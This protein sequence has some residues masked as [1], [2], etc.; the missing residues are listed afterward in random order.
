MNLAFECFSSDVSQSN[1]S[2]FNSFSPLMNLAF[3]SYIADVKQLYIV[4]YF[5]GAELYLKI[6]YNTLIFTFFGKA[7]LFDGSSLTE[8]GSPFKV[9]FPMVAV[10]GSNIVA[11]GGMRE[12]T[13]INEHIYGFGYDVYSFSADR[14]YLAVV[15]SSGIIY[16]LDDKG[17]IVTSLKQQDI[18]P[19]RKM[20]K[21]ISR[22][23]FD[24]Y[25][26]RIM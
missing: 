5:S 8:F 22:V 16:I 19:I 1:V 7:W 11:G 23:P 24:V 15:F 3:E 6:T 21:L 12:D 17:N 20:W 26:L 10:A 25:V 13:T 9:I 4:F 14:F 2:T 18:I